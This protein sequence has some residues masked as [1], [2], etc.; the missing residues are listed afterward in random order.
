MIVY[1]VMNVEEWVGTFYCGSFST[2]ELAE[3]YILR[4]ANK[5][6]DLYIN[7]YLVDSDE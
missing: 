6:L 4:H 2:K 7:E 5:G 1:N 3:A